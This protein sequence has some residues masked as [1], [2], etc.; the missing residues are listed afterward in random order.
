MIATGH[1]A[2]IKGGKLLAGLDKNKD[3]SY[4]LYR[5]N[6]D[7]LEQSL[8]PIG[9]L[10]KPEVRA[11]AKKYKLVTADKPDSQGICFVG[12]VG[13]DDFLAEFV[14]LK[15]GP[16][17]DTKTKKVLGQHDGALLYTIGQRHGLGLGGGLPYYVTNTDV[18]KNIVY[19]STQLDDDNFWQKQIKITN[20]HWIDE[21]PKTSKTY[22]VRTRYR[23]DL[24]PANIKITGKSAQVK[25]SKP[26][27][28]VAAG[29]SVVVYDG[30]QVLGGGIVN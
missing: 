15:S 28:A 26:E 2:R 29:Q 30:G 4:F 5:V 8:M 7:A 10:K 27:R 14:K 3:Q 22:Q 20:L 24:I 19:V 11:L 13:I 21:P 17:I 9:E 16:I 6:K 12:E 18:K 25:L 1:Y 23:G